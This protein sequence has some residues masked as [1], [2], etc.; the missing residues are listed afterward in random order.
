MDEDECSDQTDDCGEEECINKPGTYECKKKSIFDS[1][2]V[3][4]VVIAVAVAG[5]A[6]AA[7]GIAMLAG[8]MY[9]SLTGNNPLQGQQGNKADVEGVNA[10][11]MKSGSKVAGRDS[12]YSGSNS[13]A[14]PNS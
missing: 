14:S 3:K 4:I 10:E 8:S 6:V 7:A 2:P 1:L 9:S 11:D 13:S 5:A 12:S